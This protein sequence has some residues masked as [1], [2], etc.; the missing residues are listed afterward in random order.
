M[1]PA[2][3][4]LILALFLLE[5]Y[6]VAKKDFKPYYFTYKETVE[7]I[8]DG[9]LDGGFLAGG[10]PIASYNE[11]ATQ[12]SVRIVPVDEAILKKILADHPYYY[13]NVVK[14]K[15]YKGLEQDT[16]IMG[17]A[18]ALWT[19]SGARYGLRL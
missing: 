8:Q 12:R 5:Q 3:L 2:A 10:Y 1:V 17:F 13:K 18:G 4:R 11:L 15:S 6:G 7:G 14:A 16:T 9:S 19:H